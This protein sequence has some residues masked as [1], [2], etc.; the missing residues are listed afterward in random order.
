MKALQTTFILLFNCQLLLAQSNEYKHVYHF[1]SY[2]FDT[3]SIS[4]DT[5]ENFNGKLQIRLTT[6]FWGPVDSAM[7]IL[8]TADTVFK[9]VSNKRGIAEVY[10]KQGNYSISISVPEF[11][12]FDYHFVFAKGGLIKI[13]LGSSAPPAFY[14][15]YSKRSLTD[16]ELKEILHCLFTNVYDETKCGKKNVYYIARQI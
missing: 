3:T 13:T 1:S 4:L 7:I 15:V 12:F 2:E 8:R 14:D 5:S 6:N 10:P 16:S 9:V 11:N